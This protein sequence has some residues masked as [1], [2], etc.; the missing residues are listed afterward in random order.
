MGKVSTVTPWPTEPLTGLDAPPAAQRG[1]TT[2]ASPS[3]A[4]IAGGLLTAAVGLHV[5]AMFPPYS[6]SPATPVV[7]TPYEL[8]VYICLAAGWALA[9]LAVLTRWSVRGGVALGAGLG[10][11]EIG[12]VLTD[13]VS[14]F[15][16]S[17]GSAPGVWLAVAGVAAGLAGVLYG[18]GSLPADE[19][20]SAPSAGYP[21]R[22][23]LGVLVA[24]VAVGAFW[25][26]WDHYHV[27]TT[28]GQ[29]ENLDLGN[30]F[31]QP[32]GIMAGE[33]VA[34][35]GLGIAVIAAA[36][37]RHAATSAW[38]LGGVAIALASQVISGVVQV[39]QPISTLLGSSAGVNLDASKVSLTA[40]WYVDVAA[41][42]AIALLALWAALDA[43]R[44]KPSSNQTASASAYNDA[45]RPGSGD[46]GWPA[47]PTASGF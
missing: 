2:S 8:A 30:A 11:V 32:A 24:V 36:L 26:S 20:A 15:Q 46:L 19:Q 27:V 45:G 43:R 9:A 3:G 29:V 28:S 13:V 31:S 21:L 5:A 18:A 16:V 17:D 42:A 41:T 12:L 14:G 23:L 40:Y 34:G 4:L 39:S 1:T 35:L 44:R 22:A 37:W 10:V 38:T 47:H 33:L 6:G 25:P 7:Q